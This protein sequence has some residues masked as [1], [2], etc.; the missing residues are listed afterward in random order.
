MSRAERGGRDIDN[1]LGLALLQA[2]WLTLGEVMV[3]HEYA[4]NSRLPAF[5]A[6]LSNALVLDLR[7]CRRVVIAAL[8]LLLLLLAALHR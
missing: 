3:T 6:C 4:R 7:C 2:G 8:L 5:L 1:G